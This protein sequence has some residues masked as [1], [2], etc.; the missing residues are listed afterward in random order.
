MKLKK[1][2]VLMAIPFAIAS[3]VALADPFYINVG[4]LG[5]AIGDANTT[6]RTFDSHQVF[7][8][9]TSVIYDTNNSGSLNV[10]D[11]FIDA[12]DAH[13]TSGLPS[14]DQEGI[15]LDIGSGIIA[16]ITTQWNNLVGSIS[17]VT[18]ITT[19]SL[20]GGFITTTNYVAGGVFNF[21][22]DAPGNANYGASVG[23][24][25]DSGFGNGTHVLTLTLTSGTGS[26]TF[27]SLG[28]FV[29]G[30]SNLF[31]EITF[32]RDNFFWFDNGNGIVD[33]GDK[34]FHDLLGLLIPIKLNASVDQNTNHVVNV[35]GNGSA[36]PA[37]F[38]NQLQIIHSDHDGSIEYSVPEPTSIAL[39]GLGLLGLSFSRRNKKAA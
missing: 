35:A 16:E 26:S 18:P 4:G 34:D 27:N 1:L 33:A 2:I 28:Q 13:F 25:D 38:G 15:N 8:N 29:T 32:A 30:S 9:T 22:F 39:L 24:S 10:G 12:G 19:G 21:Y 7:A 37:G 3:G 20:T 11:K 6:T 17:A 36:G 14:G 23:T 5:P 31:A